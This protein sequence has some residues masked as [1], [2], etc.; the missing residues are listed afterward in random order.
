MAKNASKS[1]TSRLAALLRTNGDSVAPTT[2]AR[3]EGPLVWLHLPRDAALE[4]IRELCITLTRRIDGLTCLL[5]LP[6]ATEQRCEAAIVQALP[7]EQNG[8]INAFLDHWKPD[9]LLWSDPV[10][11]TRVIQRTKV[12]KTPMVMVN[13]P[14]L[15]LSRRFLRRSIA[16]SLGHFDHAQVLSAAAA[17]RLSEFG[18]PKENIRIVP[19]LAEIAAPPGHSESQRKSIAAMCPSHTRW[20]AV[21]LPLC[22]ADT[23]LKAHIE[24][25]KSFPGLG[26]LVLTAPG[27]RAQDM[28][29][30]FN[31][32]GLC[33][34]VLKT[35]AP[36]ERP[37]D[38]LISDDPADLGSFVRLS[39]VAFMGGTFAGP[40]AA[41]PYPAVALGAAVVCGGFTAPHQ[42]KFRKLFRG[43]AVVSPDSAAELAETLTETLAPDRA[44]QLATAAWKVGSEGVEAI[45]QIVDLVLREL[46]QGGDDAAT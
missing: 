18:V 2:L 13:M 45:E 34:Q 38:V 43:E 36:P 20:C 4:P 6:E 33:V 7:P 1:V 5:T 21:S 27:E 37:F 10:F 8:A 12:A 3:P 41:D 28:A 9:L 35:G 14:V 23:I 22:E 44:A 25:R 30:A 39:M 29:E 15:D 16:V 17:N 40:Q 19:P 32:A 46:P 11:R 26:L 31:D 42:E 24:A